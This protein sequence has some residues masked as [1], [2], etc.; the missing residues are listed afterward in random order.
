MCHVDGYCRECYH[1]NN[2]LSITDSHGVNELERKSNT[3]IDFE[4]KLISLSNLSMLHM[5]N[6]VLFLFLK[7]QS[8]HNILNVHKRPYNIYI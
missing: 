6:S 8:K 3:D 4:L 7:R 5:R 2:R 1:F